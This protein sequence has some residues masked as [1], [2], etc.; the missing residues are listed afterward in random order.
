MGLFS[1][2]GYPD[3]TIWRVTIFDHFLRRSTAGKEKPRG[4]EPRG[5]GVAA[6]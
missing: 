4:D 3:W 6:L 1:T 2:L 5:Q